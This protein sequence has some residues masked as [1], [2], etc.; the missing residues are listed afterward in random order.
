MSPELAGGFLTNGPPGKSFFFFFFLIAAVV[1]L[2]LLIFFRV[3]I[4]LL[5]EGQNTNKHLPA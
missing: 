2:F 1:V 3:L 5:I 4:R